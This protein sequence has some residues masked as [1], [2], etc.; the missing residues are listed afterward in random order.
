MRFCTYDMLEDVFSRVF[1]GKI[2]QSFRKKNSQLGDP[3]FGC[4]APPKT[5]EGTIIW[6]MYLLPRGDSKYSKY[7]RAGRFRDSTPPPLTQHAS[8]QQETFNIFHFYWAL[9]DPKKNLHFARVG[10]ASHVSTVQFSRETPNQEIKNYSILLK[11][12]SGSFASKTL[13]IIYRQNSGLLQSSDS[14]RGSATLKGW[15]SEK[16]KDWP[17]QAPN[18][19]PVSK[20]DKRVGSATICCLVL[21]TEIWKHSQ[22]DLWENFFFFLSNDHPGSP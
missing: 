19:P 3:G 13:P 14:S 11:K 5:M 15:I 17:L 8:H 6:K 22:L 16:P 2:S 18:K 4:Y 12:I 1:S 10:G 21:A 7:A 20:N 9:G